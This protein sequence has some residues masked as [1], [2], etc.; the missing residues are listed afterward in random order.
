MY[1]IRSYYGEGT[2]KRI[3]RPRGG[4]ADRRILLRILRAPATRAER[5]ALMDD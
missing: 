1:A 3:R 4:S 2:T 5:G